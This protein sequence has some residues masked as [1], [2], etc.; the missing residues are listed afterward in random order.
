LSQGLAQ[1]EE[2]T[3]QVGD[4]SGIPWEVYPLQNVSCR[5]YGNSTGALF[6]EGNCSDVEYLD[7]S[8]KGITRL[9]NS[10]F[11]GMGKME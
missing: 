11:A 8:G 1:S 5:F 10:T 4:D 6:R 3:W 7:L 9:Y 2:Y